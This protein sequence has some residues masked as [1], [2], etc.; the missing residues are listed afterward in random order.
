MLESDSRVHSLPQLSIG[1]SMHRRRDVHINT[2]HAARPMQSTTQRYFCIYEM[3]DT[4][5][6]IYCS[7][8]CAR[9]IQLALAHEMN[10]MCNWLLNSVINW[11]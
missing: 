11:Y 8:K 2:V 7:G 9:S 10:Q 3:Y 4:Q 5:M 1:F 6:M